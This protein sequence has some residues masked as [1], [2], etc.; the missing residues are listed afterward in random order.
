MVMIDVLLKIILIATKINNYLFMTKE[1]T[2]KIVISKKELE[3]VIIKLN[4]TKK[5]F[6]GWQTLKYEDIEIKSIIEKDIIKEMIVVKYY[7]Y[8]LDLLGLITQMK[9]DQIENS[10]NLTY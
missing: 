1:L 6:M 10:R 3:E 4:F 7:L 9:S 2:I 5:V 8:F